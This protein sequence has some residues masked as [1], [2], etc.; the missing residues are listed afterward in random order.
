MGLH[1]FAPRN[2]E[3]PGGTQLAA[4]LQE[5]RPE[6]ELRGE[7]FSRDSSGP[8]PTLSFNSCAPLWLH[9]EVG[10][11]G[12]GAK[13][14]AGSKRANLEKIFRAHIPPNVV[15]NGVGAS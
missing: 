13:R 6:A 4:G 7:D 14:R 12:V 11:S 2:K 8:L 1:S 5:G 3:S 9:K 15:G 10:C